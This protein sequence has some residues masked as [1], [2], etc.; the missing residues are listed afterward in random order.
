MVRN[1]SAMVQSSK[2]PVVAFVV[3]VIRADQ[4]ITNYNTREKNEKQEKNKIEGNV[5]T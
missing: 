1:R 3:A 2:Q 4:D 5:N